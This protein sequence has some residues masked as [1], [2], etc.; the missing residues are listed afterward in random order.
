M[1]KSQIVIILFLSSLFTYGEEHPLTNK[2]EMKLW[3]DLQQNK[4]D[5]FKN[6]RKATF[7]FDNVD[8]KGQRGY[9]CSG[10]YISDTGHI[11]TA[12]HCVRDCIWDS[13]ERE[14]KEA[15]IN[16][17]DYY[18][19]NNYH[20]SIQGVSKSLNFAEQ[21]HENDPDYLRDV[22]ISSFDLTPNEFRGLRCNMFIDKELV[23]VELLGAGVGHLWPFYSSKVDGN[24]ELDLWRSFVKEGYGASGDFAILREVNPKEN[25]PCI[26]I[27]DEKMKENEKL[28]TLSSTCT[29]KYR[30]QDRDGSKVYF[31]SGKEATSKFSSYNSIKVPQMFISTLNG[32]NCSSGSAFVDENGNIKGVM[33]QVVNYHDRT[34]RP[35]IL[36]SNIS[37]GIKADF[38]LNTL[39]LRWGLYSDDLYC[40]AKVSI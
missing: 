2:F 5:K 31:D 3:R 19:D 10:T 1:I 16:W 11:L 6:F 28:Y 35:K 24:K 40:S 25:V 22:Q 18:Y 8:G 17:F 34:S 15:G 4:K 32:E 29:R 12:L 33:V 37:V 39:R 20:H 13:L 36:D 21:D 27:T 26:S 9:S 7:A 23:E 14:K 30:N 38:I